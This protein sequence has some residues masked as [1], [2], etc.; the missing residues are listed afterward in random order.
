MFFY[1]FSTTDPFRINALRKNRNILNGD[2]RS[3]HAVE[4]R[5]NALFSRGFFSTAKP[6]LRRLLRKWA[7]FSTQVDA[8]PPLL[9]NK[10]TRTIEQSMILT[11]EATTR[12]EARGKMPQKH[13]KIK[14]FCST[15]QGHYTA[16]VHQYLKVNYLSSRPLSASS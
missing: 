15:R 9:R 11:T 10:K 2:G 16:L 14:E 7:G 3:G 6:N 12:F 13:Y 1:A 8:L 5:K 4:N